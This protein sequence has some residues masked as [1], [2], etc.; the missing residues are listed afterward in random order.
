MS[1]LDYGIKAMDETVSPFFLKLVAV[2]LLITTAIF[3]GLVY[4]AYFFTDFYLQEYDWPS[5]IETIISFMAGAGA[6]IFSMFLFPLI[7][8]AVSYLFQD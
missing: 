8:P 5:Y 3:A 1:I 6:F 2:C 7:F 4:A